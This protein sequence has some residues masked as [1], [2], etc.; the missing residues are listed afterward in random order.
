MDFCDERTADYLISKGATLTAHAAARLGKAEELRQ[1]LQDNPEA[2][3]ARG[4]D[5]QFP[6]HFS[7]TAEIVDIFGPGITAQMTY[8]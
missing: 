6:L 1:I 5:G 7:Q 4:G 2:V 8:Y 3:H